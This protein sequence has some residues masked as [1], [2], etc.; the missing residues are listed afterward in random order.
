MEKLMLLES[1]RTKEDPVSFRLYFQVNN[2]SGEK[3]ME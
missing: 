2:G 3:S 1:P